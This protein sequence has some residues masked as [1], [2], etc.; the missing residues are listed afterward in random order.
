VKSC[1]QRFTWFLAR[2]SDG[3]PSESL[4]GQHFSVGKDSVANS[5]IDYTAPATIEGWV[6][7]IAGLAMTLVTL[8]LPKLYRN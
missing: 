1:L 6:F 3:H 2:N 4:S 8:I 7:M 5:T